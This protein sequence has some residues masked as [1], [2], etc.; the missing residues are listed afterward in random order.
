MNDD[1]FSALLRREMKTALDG[2]GR[3]RP[4]EVARLPFAWFRELNATRTWHNVGPNPISFAEI[5]A[6]SLA[7][8]WPLEPRHVSAIRTLDDAWLEHFFS[9]RSKVQS[10]GKVL[11]PRSDHAVSPALFDVLFG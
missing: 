6:W 10:G 4:S 7:N 5:H 8:R 3:S 11:A 9:R 1:E 2:R